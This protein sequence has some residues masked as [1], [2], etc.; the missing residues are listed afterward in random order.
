MRD[1]IR[2]VVVDDE[3]HARRGI[4]ALLEEEDD[5]DVVGEASDG[6]EAV[7]CI[8]RLRPDLVFLDVTMPDRSGLA[9]VEDV[10]V[11]SMPQV[12]FVTAY[13]EYA[14]RAFETNAVD[15][16]LKPFSDE[17]FQEAVR[18]A[19]ENFRRERACELGER[20]RQ[21]LDCTATDEGILERF[22]LKVGEKYNV[23][24]VDQIDWIEADDYHVKL[25]IGGKS[26]LV[27]QTLGALEKQLPPTSFARIHRSTVV[28]LDRVV[29][30]EPLFQGDYTVVLK[31]GTALR[32]SRRRR[33][34]L[35]NLI[36]TFN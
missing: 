13:D 8:R 7:A 2:A 25:H 32:M 5:I 20:L 28:N 12:I 11:E 33:K 14:V 31:D 1:P 19:R 36:K 29:A 34:A 6:G 24:K 9:V 27:R 4:M 23:F 22:T 21:L 18:R 30:L 10:G 16:I 26:Y 15:Y 35:S 17:R 3:P